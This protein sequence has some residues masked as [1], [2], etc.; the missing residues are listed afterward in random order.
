MGTLKELMKQNPKKVVIISI[1]L[2]LIG[3]AIAGAGL[4]V[5]GGIVAW[6]GV[7]GI[8]LAIRALRKAKKEKMLQEAIDNMTVNISYSGGEIR[9]PVGSAHRTVSSKGHYID[10]DTI[11]KVLR[12]T[13]QIVE[14]SK[15]IDTVEYRREFG[16]EKAHDLKELE[17]AGLY[18]EHP[19]SG[20]FIDFFNGEAL[21]FINKLK[22]PKAFDEMDGHEFERYCADLLLKNGFT[23][24]EVTRGSGDHGVDI[25]AAKEGITYAIQCKRQSSNVGN[26]AVQE[27]FSG[28]EFYKRHIG[29]VITNQHFTSNAKEAAERTGVVLWDRDKLEEMIAHGR[30]VV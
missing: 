2:A 20:E 5:V 4:E 3:S 18:K 11:I 27:I 30:D 22:I 8:I 1:A 16:L 26:K 15:K 23:E 6:L 10:A 9:A 21:E 12:E 7:I 29:A 19:S 17:E 13:K 24:A 14:T 25:L 28:K